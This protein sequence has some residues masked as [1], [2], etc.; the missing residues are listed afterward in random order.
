MRSSPSRSHRA[1]D[2]SAASAPRRKLNR[3]VHAGGHFGPRS[4]MESVSLTFG[5]ELSMP[6]LVFTIAII[7]LPANF[8]VAE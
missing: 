2:N 4:G 5:L 6:A 1:I 7:D 8:A 3:R